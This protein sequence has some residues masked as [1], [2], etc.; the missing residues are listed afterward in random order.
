M[1]KRIKSNEF[2]RANKTMTKSLFNINKLFVNIQ[3]NRIKGKNEAKKESPIKFRKSHK[4]NLSKFLG[5]TKSPQKTFKNNFFTNVIPIKQKEFNK[6]NYFKNNINNQKYYSRNSPFNDSIN[7]LD[8]KNNNNISIKIISKMKKRLNIQNTH[9]NKKIN[10]YFPIDRNAIN[11]IDRNKLKSTKTI[12]LRLYE[13]FEEE[14][15]KI[16][17][18]KNVKTLTDTNYYFDSERYLIYNSLK[19]LPE[20]KNQKIFKKILKGNNNQIINNK[21]K[22]Q[23]IKKEIN[24]IISNQN[25]QK[26][27]YSL[28]K[29]MELNPYHSV[30]KNVKYSNLI[31]IQNIS[32]QLSHVNG[33]K[34][35]RASRTRPHFFQKDINFI[36]SKSLNQNLKIIDSFTVTFNNNYVSQK[37][38]LVWR[39]L[40]KLN[41]KIIL[42]SFRQAC[43]FQGYSELWKHYSLIIEK[44]LVNYTTF[45]WFITKEKYMKKQVFA[46]FLQYMDISLKENKLFPDKVYLLFDNIGNDTINIKK[47]YYIMELISSSKSIDKINF[48]LELLEDNKNKNYI[49]VSEMQEILK[50]IILYENYQKD[51]SHLHE[52][53]KNE[54]NIDK[55][56]SDLLITK[57]QLFN[58]LLNNE[59]LKRLIVLFKNQF[60]NSFYYYNEEILGGFNST[61]RN[62]K[63]LLNEQIEANIYCKHD[64]N[65]Y[66]KILSAVQ[67]K[68]ETVEKNKKIIE[69]IEINNY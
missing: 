18:N 30:P 1:K 55:I 39:I 34:L 53:I 59:F 54:F 37:G 52:I 63:K 66:D 20:I 16:N 21:D 13:N 2:N 27:K 44:M 56:E 33:I 35:N 43:I 9:S 68:R 5:N 58:F 32:K 42:S 15:I 3:K 64:I 14:L 41:K 17:D 19:T 45:K 23:N 36:N 50:S 65:N 62:V 24:K 28:K 51:Y 60:R 67:N 69:S 7:E 26:T 8:S 25:Y 11:F 47:F 46:E 49:N 10:L 48:L 38:E 6:S 4:K 57:S 61:I 29:L 31:E 12:N 22:Y 40:K